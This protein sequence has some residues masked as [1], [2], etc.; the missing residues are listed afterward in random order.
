MKKLSFLL[1]TLLVGGMMFSGCTKDP[2]PTP[3]T[4][5]D[6]TPT[7]YTVVYNVLK[8]NITGTYTL[9][10]CF[11]LDVSYMNADGE[12]V[13]ETG[14]T[15]PWSKTIEVKAP[16]HAKMSGTYVYDEAELPETGLTFGISQCITVYQ[17]NSIIS[18]GTP[19][20]T[21]FL[22]T[23]KTKFLKIVESDPNYVKFT[24]EKDIK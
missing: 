1:A 14:L 22:T 6:Q 3:D 5:P 7:T 13:N 12:M 16:F 10:D 2:D 11:K 20:A 8:Q 9:S 18:G 21:S 17:G 4:E 23:T 24:A 15:L 19:S